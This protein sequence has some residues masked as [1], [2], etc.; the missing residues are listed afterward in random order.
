MVHSYFAVYYRITGKICGVISVLG[1]N[2]ISCVFVYPMIALYFVQFSNYEG[3]SFRYRL[4]WL[5]ILSYQNTK[6]DSFSSDDWL[7][8]HAQ[9]VT[10]KLP[11]LVRFF[12]VKYW[13]KFWYK[14][15]SLKFI[16]DNW[17]N[18]NLEIRFTA[19]YV[20]EMYIKYCTWAE[21]HVTF[22]YIVQNQSLDIQNIQVNIVLHFA[23]RLIIG[24]VNT[25]VRTADE[26]YI[27]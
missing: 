27:H 20:F 11:A 26:N 24:N 2:W 8:L 7:D 17:E 23:Y 19:S 1:C 6:I 15:I 13:I 3:F 12:M 5:L 9:V 14:L 16:L 21:D 25:D 18:D 4:K 22:K 10:N